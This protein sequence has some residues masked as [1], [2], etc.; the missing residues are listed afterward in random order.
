MTP[1]VLAA[2]DLIGSGKPYAGPAVSLT[3]CRIR[4]RAVTFC[5]DM[6]NDPIQRKNRAG[7]FYETSD[8]YLLDAHFP[9]G[10][11]FV[12]IGANIGN[13]SLYFAL[14]LGAGRIIPFEPNPLCYRLLI[15][16][17]LVNR[18]LDRFDLGRLGIGLGDRQADGFGMEE[19]AHNLGAAAL[20]PGQGVISVHRADEMLRDT[21][22]DLIKIDVEGMELAVL[23]GLSGL[24]ARRRPKLFVEVGQDNDAAFRDWAAR[25]GYKILLA[26]HRYRRATNYLIGPTG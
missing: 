26:R 19:R 3:H 2:L 18:C 24:L 1:E 4:G 17:V 12:D 6:A 5:T 21:D 14:I 15:Q 11:T 22:P 8:L 20:L 7:A 10:G 25:A 13:H 9:P 16:N 23:D